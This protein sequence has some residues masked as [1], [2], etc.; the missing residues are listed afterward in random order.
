MSITQAR[1]NKVK[2]DIYFMKQN[3][4][5][6]KP[7]FSRMAKETGVSRQTLSRLWKD[8]EAL[9]RPR[10]K[11]H[12]SLIPTIQR[13]DKSLKKTPQPSKP[14]SSI[15]SL[16][17]QV[18]LL[19]AMTPSNTMLKPIGLQSSGRIDSRLM[20]VLKPIQGIRSRL[21]GKKILNSG[22]NRAGQSDLI[23]S[24]PSMDIP[25]M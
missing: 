12:P 4:P 21:T 2:G 14:S 22:S 25:D 13:S 24:L 6:I 7:N 19:K 17:I 8:D 20:F 18:Q 23:S 15:S 10:Q 16:N 3:S 11:S 9:M 5:G 1:L